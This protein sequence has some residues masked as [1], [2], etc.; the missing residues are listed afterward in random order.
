MNEM[1]E[2]NFYYNFLKNFKDKDII[3]SIYLFI[4]IYTN[5]LVYLQLHYW[6]NY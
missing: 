1:N 2:L 4:T 3:H 5:L 6:K